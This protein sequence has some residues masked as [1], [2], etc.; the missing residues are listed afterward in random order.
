MTYDIIRGSRSRF[1]VEYPPFI[2]IL[3]SYH[4]ME[5]FETLGPI[6]KALQT[7]SRSDLHFSDVDT[8]LFVET[9]YDVLNC[10][11]EGYLLDI[12]T[13]TSWLTII[14]EI[15]LYNLTPAILRWYE[16]LSGYSRFIDHGS[17]RPLNNFGF[18]VTE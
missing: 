13:E 16:M 11:Y 17:F 6:F 18:I 4:E 12:Q 1:F 8:E 15:E 5:V 10:D 9:L 3:T 14:E 7:L 2:R